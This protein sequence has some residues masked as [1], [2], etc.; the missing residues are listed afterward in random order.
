MNRTKTINQ[1]RRQGQYI[2]CIYTYVYLSRRYIYAY[3]YIFSTTKTD[4]IQVYLNC[5]TSNTCRIVYN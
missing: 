5:L 3:M 4:I 2:Q 1:V